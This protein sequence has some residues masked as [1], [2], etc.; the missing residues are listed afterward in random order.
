[1][2]KTIKKLLKISIWISGIFIFI[3]GLYIGYV[4]SNLNQDI[5]KEKVELIISE[6]KAA[7]VHDEKLISMYNKIHKNALEKSSWR[8]LW[9]WIWGENN[10]CPCFDA[11]RKTYINKRHKIAENDFAVSIKIEREVSQRDCLNFIFEDFNY[12]YNNEGVDEASEFYF[13]KSVNELNDD[14]LIGLI[15]MQKNPLLYNPKRFK[16][17]FDK[18]VNEVKKEIKIYKED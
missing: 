17:K 10:E 7:K 18:K 13:Q 8:N 1:M 5:D 4:F 3:V 15:I 9:D 2:K 11:V 6:M 12:L 14:E 16:D